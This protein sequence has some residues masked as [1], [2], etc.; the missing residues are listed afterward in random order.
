MSLQ[1]RIARLEALARPTAAVGPAPEPWTDA[2]RVQA[3]RNIIGRVAYRDDAD[4]FPDLDG[5]DY[6]DAF[7][8]WFLDN[9]GPW[10]RWAQ[11]AGVRIGSPDSA[12]AAAR[13]D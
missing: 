2:E 12:Y 9:A 7:W 13:S 6:L 11:E 8:P 4:P 10:P 1:T 5:R 3:L